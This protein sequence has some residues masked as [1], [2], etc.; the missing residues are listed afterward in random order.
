MVIIV[1]IMMYPF[2]MGYLKS[3]NKRKIIFTNQT[4]SFLHEHQTLEKIET[5]NITDVR[6]TYKDLY[7]KSQC[8]NLL[9]KIISIIFFPLALLTH[10][11][12]IFNKF[13]FHIY[14]NGIKSYRFYDAIMVFEDKKFINILPTTL[15]EY[16]EVTK[17]FK[18]KQ[19]I[20]IKNCKTFFNL[21]HLYEKIEIEGK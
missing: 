10:S 1:P 14:K 9:G 13:I 18:L 4:I 12:L 21:S 2:F 20:N 3:K 5:N 8:E 17:Y 19:N 16:E 7:H 6:K 11:F 15:K